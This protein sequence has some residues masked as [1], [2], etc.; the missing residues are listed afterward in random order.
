MALLKEELAARDWTIANDSPLAVLCVAPPGGYGESQA[1][2]N[3]VTA[4][5][6][7]WVAAAR[8]EGRDVIRICLT[9]GEATRE[10]I[11]TLVRALSAAQ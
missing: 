5:G 11:L 6:S 7:A 4:S 1:L 8:L 9:H 10:D 3:R 2:A